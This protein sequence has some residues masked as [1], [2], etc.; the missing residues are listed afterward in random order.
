MAVCPE[1]GREDVYIG[2][3]VI[4][5]SNSNCRHYTADKS[6]DDKEDDEVRDIVYKYLQDP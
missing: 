3:K 1:C 6:E 5:C 4:E 2:L